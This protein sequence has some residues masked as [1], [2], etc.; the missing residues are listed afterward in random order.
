MAR[1]G[2]TLYSGGGG[3]EAMLKDSIDFCFAAEYDPAIAA[4]Y[5]QNI[6]PHVQV[7]KV[8]EI[9]FSLWGELDYGHGSPVCKEYSQAKTGG[10]EGESD[11]T[12]A[13]AICR[14]LRACKPRV[15][16]LENVQG[17]AKGAA[18]RLICQ[19]LSDMGY[20]WHAEV[21]NSANFGVPQT[22]RRLILRAVRDALL[23]GLPAPKPWVGWYAAIEDLLPTLPASQFAPWQLERLPQEMQG[24][25]IF[26][27]NDPEWG[28]PY[29]RGA[30]PMPTITTQTGPRTRAF[31]VGGQYSNPNTSA[32]RIVQNEDAENP[33][34]TVTPGSGKDTRAWLIPGANDFR[35]QS[36]EKPAVTVTGNASRIRALL[37]HANDMRNMPTRE[38]GEPAFTI[39]A[40]S[41][42]THAPDTKPRAWLAAGRVVKMTPRALARFQS[43][44]DWYELPEKNSLAC[45]VIG[46]AVPSLMMAEIVRP[47]L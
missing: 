1:R 8:E 22:R 17:Y 2:A 6:G 27:N 18:Y 7:A 44:P 16:T 25:L 42:N 34:W 23:P 32:E 45:T 26:C 29:K 10:K 33:I 19:C 43:L 3:V 13:M 37:V 14:F 30:E 5:A 20:M 21:L 35:I 9:D 41:N 40:G 39:T 38:A 11:M 12:G 36:D 31:I 47:L 46:N 4:V 28:L 24:E 15:F